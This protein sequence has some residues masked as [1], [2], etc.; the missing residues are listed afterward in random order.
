[1]DSGGAGADSSKCKPACPPKLIAVCGASCSGK[2]TIAQK[3]AEQL[4]EDGSLVR[5]KSSSSVLS[6]SPLSQGGPL[7]SA[8]SGS[9]TDVERSRLKL[10]EAISADTFFLF[11][12]FLT[13]NCPVATIDESRRTWKDWESSTAIDWEK[14]CRE[15]KSVQ[16]DP[17]CPAYVVVEGFLLM[18]RPESRALFDIVIDIDISKEEAW[19]RRKSRAQKMAHLP[20]GFSDGEFERNYEVLESYV[21]SNAALDVYRSEALAKY[22]E[23][24]DLAWLRMYFEEVIWPMAMQQR[25]KMESVSV[26]YLRIQAEDPPG[27]DAWEEAKV[28]EVV[29]F[30]KNTLGIS[31]AASSG[32]C[33]T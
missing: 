22:P 24:G 19:A 17:L 14:Y 7:T 23:E 16:E 5:D 21:L 31:P 13:D 12:Q 29:Q 27:K 32:C 33:V 15:L 6:G 1:M 26:P 9:L 30:V 25:K 28:Q 18:D 11:D 4:C 10:S 3:L 8:R 20:P 2:S